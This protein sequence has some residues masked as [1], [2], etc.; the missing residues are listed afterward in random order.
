MWQIN[1]AIFAVAKERERERRTL[2]VHI[3]DACVYF[4]LQSYFHFHT[5]FAALFVI[6][7]ASHTWM[8]GV[9]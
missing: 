8:D 9:N 4:I 6:E 3:L 7:I 1:W 5:G 2:N